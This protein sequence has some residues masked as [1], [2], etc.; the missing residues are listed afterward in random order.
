MARCLIIGCGCRGRALAAELLAQGNVVRGT[1][2][3]AEG[4]AAISA[5][6]AEAVLADPDRLDTLFGALDHVT[7]AYVLLGSA[8]GSR[9]QLAALHGDRLESLVFKMI[10]T[11]VRVVIYEA[12]G[13]VDGALL[14][15]GAETVRRLCEQNRML[16]ELL[17]ADPGEPDAWVRAALAAPVAA[18]NG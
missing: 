11:T 13:T 18:L 8:V 6:G 7:V 2:R 14:S 15:A 12:A 9:E 4:A 10:D 16:Y 1:T 3:S 17:D 5:V